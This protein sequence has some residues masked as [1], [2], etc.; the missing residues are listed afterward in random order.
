MLGRCP[1]PNQETISCR[2]VGVYRVDCGGNRTRDQKTHNHN[3]TSLERWD[4][5]GYVWYWRWVLPNS[6]SYR[7]WMSPIVQTVCHRRHDGRCH[8]RHMVT[9]VAV[10][11]GL[12]V[13]L[14]VTSHHSPYGDWLTGTVSVVVIFLLYSSLH[15][16]CRH[17]VSRVTSPW[18]RHVRLHRV[19]CSPL[20]RLFVIWS[21]W[22]GSNN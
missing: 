5:H 15:G 10:T 6:Q 14:S 2:G 8:L 9:V 1:P 21:V 18:L 3:S 12:T 13:A 4:G 16:C 17:T 22:P 7:L 11:S 19:V 20:T